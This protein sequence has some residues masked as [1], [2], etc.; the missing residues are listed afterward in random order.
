MNEPLVVAK[1]VARSFGSG[2]GTVVALHDV[3]CSVEQGARVVVIGP[4]GSGKSTLL[5]L[6]GGIDTPTVGTV[7]W[8]ALGG[9]PRS[10]P[11]GTVGVVFQAPSLLP[12]LDATE[13]V[14]LPL[15][16]AGAS[17]D[18]ADAAAAVALEALGLRDLARLL[19]EELS[20]GQAQRVAVARA[21]APRPKLIVADEPT[22][23]LDRVAGAAVVSALEDA[24]DAVGATVVL[25]THDP[26]IASRFPE[27]W[28]MSDG[29]IDHK[30]PAWTG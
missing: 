30:E 28:V 14:A 21:L 22:G 24:A 11:A 29:T 10:L 13:N 17:D 7:T 5:H 4:S 25:A 26:S 12:A 8:P 18:E 9:H 27:R 3:T 16:L 15:L 20:A 6:L 1:G 2:S 19:P 23:R